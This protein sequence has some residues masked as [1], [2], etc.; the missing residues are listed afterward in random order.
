MARYNLNGWDSDEIDVSTF[1]NIDDD[2]DIEQLVLSNLDK[3][4]FFGDLI[5]KALS[6]NLILSRKNITL[7]DMNNLRVHFECNISMAVFLLKGI[8]IIDNYRNCE[9]NN[10]FLKDYFF[11]RWMIPPK[12]LRYWI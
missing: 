5:I 4:A 9:E 7:R 3:K 10:N 8:F 2:I 12:S 1:F 6:T 11:I